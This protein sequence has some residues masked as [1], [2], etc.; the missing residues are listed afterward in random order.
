MYVQNTANIY[1]AMTRACG[2]VINMQLSPNNTTNWTHEYLKN[3]MNERVAETTCVFGAREM[4][5]AVQDE[6]PDS[7]FVS[8]CSTASSTDAI[9][10]YER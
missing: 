1:A 5:G 2:V 8:S 10:A 3:I 6:R 4:H 9:T 7:D